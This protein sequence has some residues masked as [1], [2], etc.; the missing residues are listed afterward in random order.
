MTERDEPAALFTPEYFCD[1]DTDKLQIRLKLKSRETT[2][3]VPGG[4][5]GIRL[6]VDTYEFRYS[7]PNNPSKL[8]LDCFLPHRNSSRPLKD[9]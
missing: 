9:P 4:Q 1:P 7:P 6:A 2:P 8:A 3:P 5:I